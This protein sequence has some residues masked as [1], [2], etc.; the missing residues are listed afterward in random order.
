MITLSLN[1]AGYTEKIKYVKQSKAHHLTKRI[2]QAQHLT[3]TGQVNTDNQPN[4]DDD[5]PSIDDTQQQTLIK[6]WS[7]AE[8]ILFSPLDCTNEFQVGHSNS[9]L[10]F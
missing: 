10:F 3:P 4:I 7:N 8:T 1:R 5:Q 2:L 6:R 9:K